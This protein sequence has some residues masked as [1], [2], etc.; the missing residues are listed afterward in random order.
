MFNGTAIHLDMARDVLEWSPFSF[1]DTFNS[2]VKTE[3]E[4]RTECCGGSSTLLRSEMKSL[5]VL[6]LPYLADHY[7]SIMLRCTRAPSSAQM[8]R[9][10]I[11]LRVSTV[12]AG[13]LGGT[14]K[15]L[16]STG[17][18]LPSAYSLRVS[19]N[20]AFGCLTGI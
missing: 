12:K 11:L 16:C 8:D 9:S 15:K 6:I 10:L 17:C 20:T 19:W 5:T 18:C 2:Q 13:M 7:R 4:V 3:L 14:C 1:A